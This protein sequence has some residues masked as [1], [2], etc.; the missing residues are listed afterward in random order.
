MPRVQLQQP[1]GK[2]GKLEEIIFLFDRFG[3]TPAFGARRAGSNRIH[4]EFVE[5]AVLAGVVALVDVSVVPD[6]PK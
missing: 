5:H 3:G 1:V 4:V 2:C 6:A